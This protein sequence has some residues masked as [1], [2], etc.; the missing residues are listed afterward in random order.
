[1]GSISRAFW[2]NLVSW[3]RLYGDGVTNSFIL[4]C[5]LWCP[6][7]LH[8]W[9]FCLFQLDVHNKISSKNNWL[10]WVPQ[11][12]SAELGQIQPIVIW[13]CIST[14][15]S[16][17]YFVPSASVIIS[18]TNAGQVGSAKRWKLKMAKHNTQDSLTHKHKEPG[19]ILYTAAGLLQDQAIWVQQKTGPE[20]S[21]A[22]IIH[23]KITRHNQGE[24]SKQWL[25]SRLLDKRSN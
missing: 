1:M 17:R 12:G 14:S 21:F 4:H 3:R 24:G 22:G 20:L 5:N 15:I 13:W 11:S 2:L 23:F 6:R 25:L 19:S 18:L 7:P 8:C 10:H 9:R 16:C